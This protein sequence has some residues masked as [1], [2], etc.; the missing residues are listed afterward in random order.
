VGDRTGAKLLKSTR[1]GGLR[2][3][4]HATLPLR[5]DGLTLFVMT[6]DQELPRARRAGNG[7]RATEHTYGES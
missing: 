1:T 4:V 3:K 2:L 5:Y 6:Q 7:S